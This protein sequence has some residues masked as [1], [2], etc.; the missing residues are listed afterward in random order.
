MVCLEQSEINTA[1]PAAPASAQATTAPEVFRNTIDQV[2]A[3]V[4]AVPPARLDCERRD[5][6]PIALA[7]Q[8]AMYTAHV[9]FGLSLTRVGLI[10]RRDRTTVRHA[11]SLVEDRRDEPD[12]DRSLDLIEG[13]VRCEAVARMGF[14]P[15]QS[16]R[17]S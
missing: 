12:F 14:E 15:N 16:R 17:A 3:R 9:A 13:I 8:I 5:I 10:Y 11:C 7:R 2:V 4:F 6:A 1:F